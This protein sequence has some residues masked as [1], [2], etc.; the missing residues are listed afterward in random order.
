MWSKIKKI[1]QKRSRD[2]NNPKN[3]ENEINTT[4]QFSVMVSEH[5]MSVKTVNI[6]SST[7]QTEESLPYSQTPPMSI[8]TSPR[9][10]GY[11]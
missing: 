11:M 1:F 2:E 10:R 5:M 3:I 8:P 4:E 6:N 7:E 9:K